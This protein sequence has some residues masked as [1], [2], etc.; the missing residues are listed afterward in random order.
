MK[1]FLL[2][3]TLVLSLSASYL[4]RAS[5][6]LQQGNAEQAISLYRKAALN[7]ENPVLSYFNM[8]NA[9]FQLDSIPQSILYYRAATNYAPDF[10][11]GWLNLATA[12]YKLE[13]MGE[14]IASVR[15]AL[16]L[17]NENPQAL[18]ILGTAYRHTRAHAEAIITYEKLLSFHDDYAE[19]YIAMGELYSD[20]EDYESALKWL[21]RYPEEGSEE[22]YVH[23]LK[24]EISGKTGD[25]SRELYYLREAF[26]AN[27]ENQ[28]IIFRIVESL[29]RQK[30]GL[31]ALEEV[32][33]GLEY[34]PKFGD[35]AVLGANVAFEQG[36]L[37]L[38]EKYYTLARNNGNPNAVIGLENVRIMRMAKADS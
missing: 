4:D 18:F 24:A 30:N 28:W 3:I 33:R 12:Y 29:I 14:A 5:E 21:G 25:D 10:F 17:D 31:V 26:E 15:R 27:R 32:E 9:Y 8:G 34:F 19:A 2:L 16:L 22:G 13:D 1:P 35:L 37:D 38:A 7:G 36:N 6:E 11:R 20:L 23:I